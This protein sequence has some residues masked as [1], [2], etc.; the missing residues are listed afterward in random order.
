MKK[1]AVFLYEKRDYGGEET[2][3]C[4]KNKTLGG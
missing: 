2:K 1:I 4:E 3:K